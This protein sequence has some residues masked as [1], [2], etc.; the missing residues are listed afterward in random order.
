MT[1]E[2][3]SD[4]PPPRGSTRIPEPRATARIPEPT[5]SQRIERPGGDEGTLADAARELL[6]TDY[7]KRQWGRLGMRNRSEEVDEFGLDPIYEESFFPVLDFLHR[8]YFR[9]E[10]RGQEHVPTSGRALIVANHSGA[11]PTD[12]LMLRTALRLEH[13]TSRE[14]RWLTE[15]FITHLPFVGAFMNR[16]GAVRACQEN[17]ERLLKKDALAAVFPEGVKG[18]GKL[19]R[20]RYKLQR[21]G[22]GGFVRLAMRTGTPIIPCA[23]VGGE[24]SSPMLARLEGVGRTFGLPYLPVTP[25]FPLLGPVGLL[26]APT[27]WTIS[28]GPALPPDLGSPDDQAKV[29]RIAERV[30]ATIQ[31][32]L[33]ETLSGRR[34]VFLG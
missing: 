27:K 19:F 5:A 7:Y 25:T 4:V 6:S 13:E 16:M 30:R 9:T 29:G 21:F 26:P 20:D 3:R 1:G 32:M 2:R 31:S 11:M 17:A 18:I 8:S 12:G 34:S 23:I 15:D 28:F 33:D 22:R 10:V 14:V 24:E